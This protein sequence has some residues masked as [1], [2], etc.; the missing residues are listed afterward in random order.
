M[1]KKENRRKEGREYSEVERRE[2]IQRSGGKRDIKQREERKSRG[3]KR[4]EER[5]KKKKSKE[6]GMGKRRRHLYDRWGEEGI[7]ERKREEQ[8]S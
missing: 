2:R 5:S 3:K 8:K 1:G 4:E 6:A 7:E